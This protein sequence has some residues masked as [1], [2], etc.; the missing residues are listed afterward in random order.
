MPA[1]KQGLQDFVVTCSN[2]TT[3]VLFTLYFLFGLKLEPLSICS[4]DKGLKMAFGA[5]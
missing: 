5:E 2:S 3:G 4:R 1:P